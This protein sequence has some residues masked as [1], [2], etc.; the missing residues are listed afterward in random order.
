[1]KAFCLPP[2]SLFS[3][4]IWDFFMILDDASTTEASLPI[5]T[6]IPEFVASLKIQECQ[7]EGKL[8]PEVETARDTLISMLPFFHNNRI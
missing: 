1:M 8:E 5:L 3:T 4:I 6:L 7:C 2:D